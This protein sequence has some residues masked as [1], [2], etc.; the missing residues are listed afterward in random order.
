MLTK[1]SFEYIKPLG[2]GAYGKVYQVKKKNSEDFFAL[3]EL[4]KDR[5]QSYGKV[6]SVFRERDI[7]DQFCHH[8]NIIQ[9]ECTFQDENTLYFL[10]EFAQ[11][12]PLT[13]LLKVAKHLPIE[14]S[15]FIIAEIILALEY[16]HSEDI[17]HR[18]LKPDN[19]LLD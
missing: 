4:D 16:L 11:K 13:K 8:K 17:S 3:K 15:R 2:E 18:D 5:I 6:E 12:G 14:T 10:M 1:D 19:I 7:L 9:L